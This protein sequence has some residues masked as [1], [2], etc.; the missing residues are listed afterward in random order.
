MKALST[1][2]WA[3]LETLRGL[4]LGFGSQLVLAV[5]AIFV[6]CGLWGYWKENRPAF[7]LL[8][9]PTAASRSWAWSPCVG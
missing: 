6:G 9:I 1:P 3:L 4:Q 5:G 2:G 8:V 7:L